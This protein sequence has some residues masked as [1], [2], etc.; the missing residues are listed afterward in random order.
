MTGEVREVEVE[1]QKKREDERG[2]FDSGTTTHDEFR[3]TDGFTFPYI[4]FPIR[5]TRLIRLIGHHRG[6][7]GL[8]ET[9]TV[10][11]DSRHLSY[12]YQSHV[13]P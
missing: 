9:K 1:V 13:C 5:S 8:T 10:C 12:P 7:S 11:S 4:R 3:S 2:D 6:Q